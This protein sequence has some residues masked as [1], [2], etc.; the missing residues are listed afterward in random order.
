[1]ATITE[2]RDYLAPKE[3]AH[4]LGVDVSVVYR[5]VQ[6]GEL[7]AVRLTS[8]GAI[9]I[10]RERAQTGA[11]A[12]KL[13]V[14]G[15]PPSA[16]K[17]EPSIEEVRATHVQQARTRTRWREIPESQLVRRERWLVD[18]ETDELFSIHRG[19]IFGRDGVIVFD[20]QRPDLVFY[21]DRDGDVVVSVVTPR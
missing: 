18:A 3:V 13:G 2:T 12:M 8:R 19:A 14:I 15:S 5:A 21:V 1:M 9:R 10:P 11:A 6:S 7:P 4:T 20:D 17:E 16:F